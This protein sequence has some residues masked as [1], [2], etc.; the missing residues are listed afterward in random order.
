MTSELSWQRVDAI[1]LFYLQPYFL[2]PETLLPKSFKKAIFS[3]RRLDSTPHKERVFHALLLLLVRPIKI[4]RT[5]KL[6][7]HGKIRFQ[8]LEPIL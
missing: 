2:A 6:F 4:R 8:I 5:G 7:E 3:N 1:C